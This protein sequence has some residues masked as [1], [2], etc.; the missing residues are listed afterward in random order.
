MLFNCGFSFTQLINKIENLNEKNK[1]RPLCHPYSIKARAILHAHLNRIP[2]NENT[3]EQDRRYI[4]GKCPYLIQEQVNC[5]HHLAGLA[6]A[7]Q[8]K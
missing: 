6:Y 3:L 5:V 4:V 1:E 7:R 2:L 8:S